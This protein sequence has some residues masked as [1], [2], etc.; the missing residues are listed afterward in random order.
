[1]IKLYLKATIVE[2]YPEVQSVHI[3]INH[4]S[5]CDGKRKF[6]YLDDGIT[7]RQYAITT[8][9]LFDG[10]E[11]RVLEIERE[12]RSLSM[13]ILSSI[14]TIN[15]NH[16]TEELL[17][18]LVNSSGVWEKEWLGKLEQQGI[19]VKKAKHSKKDYKHRA[20]LLLEKLL[21]Y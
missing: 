6:S 7:N 1:M 14:L 3:Q 9:N 4:L 21:K 2:N 16:V 10:M 5:T 20:K 15:W 13:L 17:L 19:L 12:T 11:Y 8:I 18:N